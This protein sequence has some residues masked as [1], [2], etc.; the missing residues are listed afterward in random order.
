MFGEGSNLQH[1][2][3]T[4]MLWERFSVFGTGKLI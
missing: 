1:G 2:G 3:G 4:I